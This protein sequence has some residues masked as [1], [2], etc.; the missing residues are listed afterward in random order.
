MKKTIAILLILVIGMVGVFAGDGEGTPA[1]SDS[2]DLL[3]KTT[4]AEYTLMAITA[5]NDSVSWNTTTATPTATSAYSTNALNLNVVASGDDAGM[6]KGTAYLQATSNRRTGA[7]I[8][9]TA[10]PLVSEVTVGEGTVKTYLPYSVSCNELSSAT[11]KTTVD[12]DKDGDTKTV[13]TLTWS[14]TDG[15][16]TYNEAINISIQ[17]ADRA[18]AAAG[19]YSGNIV[20]EIS[21]T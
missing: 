19:E 1:T 4:I 3:F 12:G 17:A 11:G 10:K 16:A 14:A 13:A 15:P 18:K 21:A 7:T 5:N 8:T 9:M 20:F 6:A 2:T